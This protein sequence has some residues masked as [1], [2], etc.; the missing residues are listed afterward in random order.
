[1]GVLRRGMV[2]A[3]NDEYNRKFLTPV[4]AEQRVRPYIGS[5]FSRLQAVRRRPICR[6]ERHG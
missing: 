2:T 1:M 3:V 5:P 6:G 4:K